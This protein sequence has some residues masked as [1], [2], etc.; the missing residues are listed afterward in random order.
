[1]NKEIARKRRAKKTKAVI[2]NTKSKRPRLVV[3]RSGSH[4]YSQI[5]VCGE[6]GDKVLAT[7]STLD[8]ELK[9]SLTGNKSEQAA[10]VGKLLA[11]RAKEKNILD[12]AFDRAGY[13]YHGRVKAL[14]EGARE[15]GLNF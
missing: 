3:H 11:M 1:M 10:Q 14:A 2:R 4:I 12:V 5:I 8:K 6:M 7:A 15:G 13:R 9:A